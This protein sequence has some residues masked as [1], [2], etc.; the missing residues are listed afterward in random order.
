MISG[1]VITV[2]RHNISFLRETV[3]E[4]VPAF[5]LSFIIV[6]VSLLTGSK[7]KR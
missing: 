2:V 5:F 1:S 4:L 6:I 7:L 3:Y